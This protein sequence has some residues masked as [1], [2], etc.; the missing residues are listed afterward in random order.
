MKGGEKS[1]RKTVMNFIALWTLIAVCKA[2]PMGHG[3][4]DHSSRSFGMKSE[5]TTQQM[6]TKELNHLVKKVYI[7]SYVSIPLGECLLYTVLSGASVTFDGRKTRV[8]TG[9]VGVSPGTSI[10]G[11]YILYDGSTE[12]TTNSA[13]L[14]TTDLAI[15]YTAASSAACTFT[16][17]SAE[18][19][20]LNLPPGVYCSP[21]GTLNLA[22]SGVL[23]LD[24]SNDDSAQWVFQTT[25][26]VIT[27]SYSSIVAVNRASASNIF[28][29]VGTSAT[30]GSY[31]TFLG[32]IL[33]DVAITLGS[34]CSLDGRALANMGITCASGCSIALPGPRV[35]IYP[36]AGINQAMFF[37]VISIIMII[38]VFIV[39]FVLQL[40][41]TIY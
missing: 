41:S 24:A 6:A 34:H 38:N 35:S 1:P 4:E 5:S 9:D 20:S 28:W 21:S 39:V 15:A 18:L 40:L 7:D 30:I 25:T 29:A 26:T 31:S 23:T 11:N 36:H 2:V 32:T 13:A 33:S 17:A 37:Y 10:T 8:Y 16:L 22:S 14:C 3:L 12:S 19:A 27:G